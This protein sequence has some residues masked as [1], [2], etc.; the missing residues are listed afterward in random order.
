MIRPF[1]GVGARA[2]P[3][4][5]RWPL[6][7]ALLVLVTVSAIAA[8]IRGERLRAV[9]ALKSGLGLRVESTEGLLWPTRMRNVTLQVSPSLSVGIARLELG[10]FPWPRMKRAH[11]VVIQG[12]AP[13]DTFWEDA[14]RF[15]VPADLEVMDARLEYT[16]ASGRT[17]RADSASFELGS[18]QDHLHFQSLHAFGATFHDVHLWA[19]RASTVLEIRIAREADDSKSPKQQSP[20][21]QP[22]CTHHQRRDCLDR[23]AMP[24]SRRHRSARGTGIGRPK[25]RG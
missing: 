10:F 8:W 5:R 7:I 24:R 9:S 1:R 11:G 21:S 6:F 17:L 2:D 13:L 14:R 15:T 22:R 3:N 18:P 23:R 20:E 19:N 25:K 16:D 12:R 4:A